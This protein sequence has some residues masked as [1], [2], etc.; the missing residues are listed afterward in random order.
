MMAEG[1]IIEHLE[2][3]NEDITLCF[4]CPN[5][6][7]RIGECA[8]NLLIDESQPDTLTRKRA[9]YGQTSD[10]VAFSKGITFAD[11]EDG[12]VGEE[13][14]TNWDAFFFENTD[15]PLHVKPVNLHISYPRQKASNR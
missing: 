5:Y 1:S 12:W 11:S 13:G 2:I 9:F 7:K 14:T 15:Y 10:G 3:R 4:T 6:R 8:S